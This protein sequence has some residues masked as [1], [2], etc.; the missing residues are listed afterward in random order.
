MSSWKETSDGLG[1]Q[2]KRD[3][4]I[5]VDNGLV[6]LKCKAGKDTEVNGTRGLSTFNIDLVCRLCCFMLC[7]SLSPSGGG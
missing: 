2:L 7:M 4:L 3:I 5:A 6:F 1:G